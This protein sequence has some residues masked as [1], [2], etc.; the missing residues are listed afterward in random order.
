[1]KTLLLSLVM[2]AVTLALS[3]QGTITSITPNSGAQNT[4]LTVQISG[5]TGSFSPGSSTYINF[6]QGS[7]SYFSA[8]TANV[9]SST[10]LSA[11]VQ[12]PAT[13]PTGIYDVSVTDYNGAGAF[14]QAAFTVLAGQVP[15]IVSVDTNYA[16]PG[17]TLDVT[18][19]G[20][21]T[22]FD[23][24][25]GTYLYFYQ[26]SSSYIQVNSWNALNPTTILANIS[27]QGNQ[28]LGFYDLDVYNDWDGYITLPNAFVV[29]DTAA[30]IVVVSPVDTTGNDS[31]TLRIMGS[32][33]SF[34]Y[35]GSTTVVWLGQ[36]HRGS[37][38]NALASSM[39]I[40]NS[41][42]LEATFQF[43]VG[44]P[45]GWYD[46][47]VLNSIDGQLTREHAYYKNGATGIND[48]TAD[49]IAIYPNPVQNQLTLRV[50]P[51][52]LNSAYTLTDLTGRTVQRGTITE[53][54]T[55]ISTGG[56][57]E[58]V[59]MLQI[60]GTSYKIVKE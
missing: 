46:L 16:S 60:G 23:Q 35:P 28:P 2:T 29:T 31:T 39:T 24:G 52:E 53:R 49:R 18:I 12:I 20:A 38:P 7:Y 9:Q 37:V 54:T 36:T 51:A 3:A 43:P 21:D 14:A 22:H 32:G 26:G 42:T 34:G 11:I 13:A 59:Y 45:G 19:S 27:L 25:T 48:A 5:T 17:T 10:S 55:T 1:M 6:V 33:T 8:Y 47:Y 40:I 15:H 30:G 44:S 56:L 41:N 57:T 58:G 50:T 4:Q